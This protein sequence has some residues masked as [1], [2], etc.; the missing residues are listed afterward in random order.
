MR[1]TKTLSLSLLASLLYSNPLLAQ[2][3]L[4]EVVVTAS[5]FTEEL[6]TLPGDVSIIT[7]KTI[8]QST[9]QNIPHLI[10]SELGISVGDITGNGRN[11]F[12]DLRSFG[13]TA[14]ANTLVLV[15]GRR[16]NAPDLSG[17]DW[18]QT[19]LDRIQKIEVIR[20]GSTAV[21]YG[22]NASAGV[23][24]II[25][26]SGGQ[27]VQKMDLVAGSFGTLKT[28]ISM[29][30][31][32]KKLSFTADAGFQRSDGYRINSG[33]QAKNTG[34]KLD[35]DFN[36][37]FSLNVSGGYNRDSTEWPGALKKSDLEGGYSHTDTLYPEDFSKTED[38]FFKGGPEFHFGKEH[39]FKMDISY[40]QRQNENFSSGDWGTFFA[41]TN[42]DTYAVA[43]R[44]Q[45][46]H[47]GY[48][49]TNKLIFGWDYETSQLDVTND[50]LFFGDAST[51][52]FSFKKQNTA[53]YLNDKL[54]LHHRWTLSGGYRMDRA[55]YHFSPSTPSETTL[56][57]E[58]VSA[59]LGY[60]VNPNSKLYLNYANSFRYPLIDEQF[61]Y[62][63]NTVDTTLLPQVAKEYQIGIRHHFSK[64]FKTD[65]NLFQIRTDDEI[66]YDPNTFS[67]TNM[68]GQIKR[69]G[70]TLNF[71]KQFE[72]WSLMGNY[73]WTK[74]SI[75]EGT[76]ADKKFPGVPKQKAGLG[77]HYNPSEPLSLTLNGNYVG[78][79]WFIS[80]FNN[81]FDKQPSYL[82]LDSGMHYRWPNITGFIKVTNLTEREYSEYAVLG[83]FPTEQAYYP[84]P[85][86]KIM[87][88]I[89]LHH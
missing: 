69:E 37:R 3:E 6:A 58:A 66:Y 68:E 53:Y 27:N 88:G 75:E 9:A 50:A 48:G 41:Q 5:R 17:T 72:Q 81:D 31:L 47:S 56:D 82:L 20:G 83:G 7:S 55:N 23:I 57:Q 13:E 1:H 16:V 33:S 22:D 62:F 2:T 38:F 28:Q 85:G 34:F 61:N 71:K 36:D 30:G 74:S 89:S 52:D 15:D 43:P 35:Y 42:M 24:N 60:D 21:L 29:D 65:L 73:T 63:S 46:A 70:V 77:I 8:R 51:A 12:V 11:Y 10:Q 18:L 84:S 4:E 19:P 67:N 59:T 80:D 25:T 76:Y 40:R 44:V 64:T 78:E 49:F 39:L 87:V 45:L 14:S 26:R 86:R 79:K 32:Y 54:Q